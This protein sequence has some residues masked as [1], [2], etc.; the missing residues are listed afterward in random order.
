MPLSRTSGVSRL[1]LAVILT[2]SPV[3]GGCLAEGESPDSAA[4]A[5]SVSQPAP[6]AY[7]SGSQLDYLDA[8]ERSPQA[9]WGDVLT[10]TLIARGVIGAPLADDVELLAKSRDAGLIV[11]ADPS[12][13]QTVTLLDIAGVVSRALG[14]AADT[15]ADVRGAIT[16]LDAAGAWPAGTQPGWTATGPQWLGILAALNDALAQR[17]GGSSTQEPSSTTNP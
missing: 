12:P 9:T 7:R 1:A 11:G 4:P 17:P 10:G 2:L 6:P 14:I 15:E 13:S 5:Q 8:L 16:R 3:L